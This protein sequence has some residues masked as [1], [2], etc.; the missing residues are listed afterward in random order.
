LSTLKAH[1]SA[2]GKDIAAVILEPVPANYGLWIP[3]KSVLEEIQSLCKKNGSLFIFDE[4]I[5]GFR[6]S[7]GGASERFGMKPDLVTLGKIVGGGLPLAAI[8][9]PAEIMDTLA[10][11][12]PVYQAG[13]LSGNPLAAAAGCAVL[14][15]LSRE[16]PFES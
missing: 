4:V 9:G 6:L 5:T 10:P 3:S 12:G 16:N 2:H 7:G 14:D 13:T 11:K 1:F 8:T 15:V